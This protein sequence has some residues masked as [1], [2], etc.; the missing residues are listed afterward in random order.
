MTLLDPRVVESL[1][2]L[3]E[4]PKDGPLTHPTK[5]E[6][7]VYGL[8]IGGVAALALG[9][10]V[11]LSAVDKAERERDIDDAMKLQVKH[12]ASALHGWLNDSRNEHRNAPLFSITHKGVTAIDTQSDV[13]S[14]LALHHLWLNIPENKKTVINVMSLRG[15]RDFAVAA[16]NPNRVNS[17]GRK[18][19]ILV[20]NS[21]THSFYDLDD[22]GSDQVKDQFERSISEDLDDSKENTANQDGNGPTDNKDNLDNTDNSN[23]TGK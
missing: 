3:F 22:N 13:Y 20:Y 18:G 12:I 9:G 5:Q 14:D 7:L 23:G 2:S 4:S 17:E 15:N 16:Y 8:L 10:I 1:R 11:A 21:T 19:V 6:K